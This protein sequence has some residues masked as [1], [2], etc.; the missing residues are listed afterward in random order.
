M[1]SAVI[2]IDAVAIAAVWVLGAT[3]GVWLVFDLKLLFFY[4][5]LMPSAVMAA[6]GHGLQEPA[7]L[8]PALVEFLNLLRPSFDCALLDG[9]P[10][11]GVVGAMAK[12]HF[13]FLWLVI[14]I[15]SIAG[16]SYV[17]LW[18][19]VAIL[20]GTYAAGG[21]ALGRLF[22][23][24][25]AAITIG[26]L[27]ALSPLSTSMLAFSLRDHAKGPFFLWSLVMTVLLL[28]ARSGGPLVTLSAV[29]GGIVGIGAG[30]RG[31]LIFM[32]PLGV[33]A[34]TA[35]Q[36]TNSTPIPARIGATLCFL[37]VALGLTTPLYTVGGQTGGFWMQ[38]A[39]EPFRWHLRLPPAPYD[40]GERYSD[41]LTYAAIGADL[42]ADDP[43]SWDAAEGQPGA[44]S[45]AVRRSTNYV[46]GWI[47][48]FAA[49]VATRALSSIWLTAG[50]PTLLELP[51]PPV[52]LYDVV[53]PSS[54]KLSGWLA[55][56]MSALASRWTP[57]VGV[58]G[59]LGLLFRVFARSRRE[60]GALAVILAALLALPSLQFAVRHSFHLETVFWLGVFSLIVLPFSWPPLSRHAFAFIKYCAG[61]AFLVLIVYLVLRAFQDH[62][63]R[64]EIQAA[65]MAPSEPV[66]YKIRALPG[67][68][69]FLRVDAPLEAAGLFGSERDSMS[70]PPLYK[71][72]LTIR[73]AGARML[74]E[75]GSGCRDLYGSMSL[76]YAKLPTVWQAMDRRIAFSLPAT[77]AEAPTLII[78]P[79]FYR[80]SQAFEGIEL[81]ATAL[82]CLL[83]LRWLKTTGRLPIIFSG[84]FTS[85][86]E[87]RP[88]YL[89]FLGKR[90]L[91]PPR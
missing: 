37:V 64:G 89:S 22:L 88:L 42:R 3:V 57:L 63:L 38:G 19:L 41:E 16:V 32:L 15:W 45:A 12:G 21:F 81:P 10:G 20:H 54:F 79:A 61:A 86:W 74:F 50:L 44:V 75:F 18:P 53:Y 71:G 52:V 13:Y 60:A 67:D 25:W 65:I 87:D 55:P 31:D 69:V 59:L 4:Q 6:C 5:N 8:T 84:V 7:Q 34:L 77:A 80:P 62:A 39:S 24:R 58:L 49:D 36:F 11:S 29:F 85:G 27:L 51:R 48:L 26:V 2:K 83:S 1:S 70:L 17:V 14:K 30:F 46:L 33:I 90:G 35:G 76:S 82:P 66:S 28:R 43:Q 73:A 68:R 47:D 23:P 78:A 9:V 72:F 91:P 40:L 56:A